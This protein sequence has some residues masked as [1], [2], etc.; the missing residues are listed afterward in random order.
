MTKNIYAGSA[1]NKAILMAVA[2]ALIVSFLFSTSFGFEEY[3]IGAGD[4][5]SVKVFGEDDLNLEKVRVGSNGSISFPLLGAVSV[6]GITAGELESRLTKMLL[7][8]YMKKPKVTVS[9]LEYRMFFVEGEVNEPGGYMYVDGLTVQK[10]IVLAG[11]LTERASKKK[12]KLIREKH[13]DE[14]LES[15]GLNLSVNPG[16]IIIVGVSFF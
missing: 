8:G 5:L 9:I 13:P 1:V 4:L 3:R 16:D 7:D 12:I 10:G 14:P 6:L 15:V 11:G 2:S